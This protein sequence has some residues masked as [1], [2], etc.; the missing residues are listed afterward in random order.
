MTDNQI[1]SH[2]RFKI[3]FYSVR[4]DMQTDDVWLNEYIKNNYPSFPPQYIQDIAHPVP[5]I[6]DIECKSITHNTASIHFSAKLRKRDKDKPISSD[7]LIKLES[8]QKKEEKEAE[9]CTEALKFDKNK[10]NYEFKLTHL[11][12]NTDYQMYF[13]LYESHNNNE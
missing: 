7:L 6:D 2:I 8:A 12:M 10:E 13:N 11:D 9:A 3:N 1:P 5:I 4:G